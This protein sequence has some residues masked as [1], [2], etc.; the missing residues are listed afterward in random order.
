MEE[1]MFVENET[2]LNIKDA[3]IVFGNLLF[4]MVMGYVAVRGIIDPWK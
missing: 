1:I 2:L 4:G 3:I